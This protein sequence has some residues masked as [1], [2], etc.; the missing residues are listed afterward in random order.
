LQAGDRLSRLDVWLRRRGGPVGEP[1]VARLELFLNGVAQIID[2]FLKLRGKRV[3]QL[4][5]CRDGEVARYAQL[6]QRVGVTASRHDC[7]VAVWGAKE[8]V[9]SGLYRSLA[10]DTNDEASAAG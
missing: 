4:M 9:E 1:L 5:S 8:T 7:G 6:D 10:H 2:P 3:A